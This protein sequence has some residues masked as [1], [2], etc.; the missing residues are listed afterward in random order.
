M[1][2]PGFDRLSPDLEIAIFRVVQE[3]L[4][5][6]HRHSG[7]Q[8]AEVRLARKHGCVHLEISDEGKGIPLDKQFDLD[9][10]GTVPLENLDLCEKMGIMGIMLFDRSLL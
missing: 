9:S 5:N 2:S 4:T 3:C 10:P 6:V 8:K 1:I 7:S